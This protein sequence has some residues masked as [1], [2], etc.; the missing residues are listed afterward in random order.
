MYAF[1]ESP[2]EA[3]HDVVVAG[4]GA[5]GLSAALFTARAGLDTVVF[6][7]GK[8]AIRQCAHVEN[9][10]GFP[11]GVAPET[12]LEL[13]RTQVR[14]E[15]VAVVDERVVDV[16]PIDDGYR[17]ETT[18][19]E[20]TATRVVA[21]SAYDGEFLPDGPKTEAGFA[22]T[23]DGFGRT[24]R[25][26]LYVT[27]WMAEGGVHQVSVNAGRGAQ[28][29]VGLVRD[30]MVARGYWPDLA[31]HYVDWVVHDG[32]YGG[33]EW[34]ASIRSFLA[35]TAPEDAADEEFEAL[36]D[37]VSE[38]FLSR[39]I[40]AE[41]RARRVERGERLLLEHVSDDTIRTYL[42]ERDDD[43]TPDGDGAA[44]DAAD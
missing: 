22:E 8:S 40:D 12:F 23:V 37:A 29:G 1:E 9:Y 3:A 38:Q 26:G 36:F 35:D 2:G 19:G 21:A 24:E 32:R 33:E 43:A 20:T 42:A 31:E 11:G 44:A 13:G 7:G 16:T 41:E 10:L 14:E 30:E 34:E 28:V 18:D 39:Q 15:G 5:A 17:V 25:D 4:G 6:D 27:G